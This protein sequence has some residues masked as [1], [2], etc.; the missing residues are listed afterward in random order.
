MTGEPSQPAARI[1]HNLREVH[2][3]IAAAATASGRD[4]G[5]VRLVAV[6][7]FM[8]VEALEYAL[9][10]GQYC[11]GENYLQEVLH[12]QE[13]LHDSRIE[14]HYIGHLQTNKARQAAGKFAWLHT[15]DN[16]RLA[17]R[18]AAATPESGPTLNVLLQVNV[19]DDPDK[20]G[21]CAGE[22]PRF[23]ETLL[24]AAHPGIRLCGLMTIGRLQAA[25]GERRAEFAAL[26][27]LSEQCGREFG[28]QYF[29]ELSMGMSEDFEAAIAEGATMVRI[30]SAIFGT[31]PPPAR[32]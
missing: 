16:L 23:A 26:R 19:A 3:R 5:A 15:L 31:R 11:F 10:A 4:S 2:R 32:R 29:S 25:P 21:L 14:W 22:V 12:K 6:S 17:E 8:P 18:I 24:R 28:Q 7:K 1:R 20:H 27:R 30:G 9:A 13:Q